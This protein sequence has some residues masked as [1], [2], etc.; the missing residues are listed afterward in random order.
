[1]DFLYSRDR[2]DVGR[3][4]AIIGRFARSYPS[5]RVYE[6]EGRWGCFVSTG[7]QY[8]SLAPHDGDE[9]ITIVSGDPLCGAKPDVP[10]EPSSRTAAIARIWKSGHMDTRTN[11]PCALIGICKTT[12]TIEI[13]TDALGSI[14]VYLGQVGRSFAFGSSPDLVAMVVPSSFDRL[15]AVERLCTRQI[16]FPHTLYTTIR[17]LP[18]GSTTVLDQS[19]PMQS[20][21]WWQAPHPEDEPS[22]GHW[23]ERLQDIVADTFR[24]I[25]DQ[26]S[27]TGTITLSAGLDSRFLLSMIHRDRL[28]DVEAINISSGPNLNR[29]IARQVARTL[30]VPL[31]QIERVR[32]HYSA[33]LMDGH[34]EIGT[35]VCLRDAHF[36]PS[37][38]GE[39]AHPKVLL[40][41]FMADPILVGRDTFSDRRAM[42]MRSGAL[43]SSSPFWA[44]DRVYLRFGEDDRQS[45]AERWRAAERQIGMD[46]QHATPMRRLLP[47]TRAGAKGHFESARRAYPVYE[48]FMTQRA[49]ELGFKMR[50]PTMP[51]RAKSD[52]Y[53]PYLDATSH[54]PVNPGVPGWRKIWGKVAQQVLPREMWPESWIQPGEWREEKGALNKEARRLQR[55]AVATLSDQ[56]SVDLSDITDKRLLSMITTTVQALER[57]R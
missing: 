31:T 46:P 44:A 36:T 45:I 35:N 52:F 56:L 12:G 10:D 32:D 21:R 28:L 30:D 48:P 53:G 33:I 11:H 38:L 18:P 4:R 7:S 14:P 24:M 57:C 41:G 3:L 40:S 22:Q 43:D 50:R 8:Q 16:T 19:R 9:R 55:A 42:A 2:G 6:L 25:G 54:I 15:S 47:A 5:Q 37:A 27:T 29:L 34:P 51:E 26:V 23:A 39:L 49:L 1:M 13:R 20:T 17:E